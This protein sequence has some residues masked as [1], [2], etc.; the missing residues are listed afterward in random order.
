[1]IKT[2]EIAAIALAVAACGG[3]P[4]TSPDPVEPIA[5]T[6]A[7]EPKAMKKDGTPLPAAKPKC[8]IGTTPTCD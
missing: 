6:N 1:M 7:S 3:D 4:E 2:T 5:D 8:G